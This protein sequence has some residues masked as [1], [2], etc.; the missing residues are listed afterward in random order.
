MKISLPLAKSILVASVF[1]MH[2]SLYGQSPLQRKYELYRTNFHRQFLGKT[3]DPHQAGNYLPVE[4]H[5]YDGKDNYV[6][7]TWYMGMYLAVLATEYHLMSKEHKMRAAQA[8]LQEIRN[9][10]T[11]INRLDSVAE[12]YYGKPP[13][14][15]GF[16][17][18]RD[19][20]K[21]TEAM[22]QD[23]VWGLMYGFRFI[24]E[25][26]DEKNIIDETRAIARRIVQAMNPVVKR[27]GKKEK[28]AWMI[29]A[30]NG[31]IIQ[32]EIDLYAT[33]YAF[34]RSLEVILGEKI[35]LPKGKNLFSKL[36]YHLSHA[37]AYH[38]L[39]FRMDRN[40]FNSYGILDLYVISEP[41]KALPLTL[42]V[43]K[44]VHSYYPVGVFAHFPLSAAILSKQKLPLSSSYY[45]QILESAPS[46]NPEFKTRSKLWKRT[47]IFGA[48]WQDYNRGYYNG[49]DYM[50]L[51]N[52]Y[53]IYFSSDEQ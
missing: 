32:P 30:P 5:R 46:S 9:I 50:L 24:I 27:R 43:E 25:Y 20:D 28:H 12:T 23:Q 26:V 44:M 34:V 18:R 14:L 40:M 52:L 31:E 3:T 11:T 6:D 19:N 1:L 45:Q 39:L 33:R 38:H 37:M 17:V 41:A 2:T 15:N 53:R 48:F 35:D 49:L 42:Q 51:Y 16:F 29:I 8:S 10:L 47:N 13:S 4:T 36:M 22:S 7:V 21:K